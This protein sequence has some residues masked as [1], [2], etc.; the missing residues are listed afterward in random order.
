MSTDVEATSHDGST[1]VFLKL[2]GSLITDK[3]RPETARADVLRRL[4]HEIH[5]AMDA[6]PDL[7]LVLGHGSG[8]FGHV[9]AR[10]YGTRNSVRDEVGWLGFAEVA[11]AAA[12]LNRLVVERFL[13]ANLPVWSVQPSAGAWC[14]DGQIVA[15]P[16]HVLSMALERGLIPLV[17]GDTVLDK[18]RGG[19]IASTEEVFA[20]LVPRL[21]PE[22]IVLAGTV[23]GVFSSDPILDANA[24]QWA[25]I[26]PASLPR[27]RT[28]LGGSHG[29]DVTG[30]M[31]SKVEEM[32]HLV[33]D[34]P[35]LEVRLVSG[36]RP[37][38]VRAALLAEEGSGGTLIRS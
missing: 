12:R 37:G 4:A 16:T 15:W 22:R 7:S 25:E 31:L 9:A 29:V 26:N 36:L 27:L 13:Q 3:T 28:H 11:D 24:R 2:G 21:R 14:D 20:W 23:D 10:R 19:T 34:H 33:S 5:A 1:L 38:A 32:C 18:I 30:G 17:Y 6:A 35:G 8:S